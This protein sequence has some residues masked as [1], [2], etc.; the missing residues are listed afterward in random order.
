MEISLQT[1]KLKVLLLSPL[2]AAKQ[3]VGKLQ[4]CAC[5]ANL[6]AFVGF[7]PFDDPKSFQIKKFP[8][9]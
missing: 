7:I 1:L 3:Q 2:F 8:S 9:G 6:S 5:F 4:S